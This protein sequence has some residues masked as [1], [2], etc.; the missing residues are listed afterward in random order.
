MAKQLSSEPKSEPKEEIKVGSLIGRRLSLLEL[1]K[2]VEILGN[3]KTLNS[4]KADLI[5]CEKGVYAVSKKTG[6]QYLIF[7]ADCVAGKLA[8]ESEAKG[9]Q[10]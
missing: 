1:G 5:V 2:P 4:K 6:E 7:D 9:S 8:P 10:E 3:T